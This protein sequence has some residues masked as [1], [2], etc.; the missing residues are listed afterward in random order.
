MGIVTIPCLV[1]L[2]ISISTLPTVTQSKQY[3]EG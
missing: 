2:N 3:D 1:R